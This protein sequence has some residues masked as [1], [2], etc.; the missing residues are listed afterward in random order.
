MTDHAQ[1]IENL[2]KALWALHPQAAFIRVN[3]PVSDPD[4]DC[5]FITANIETA[6]RDGTGGRLVEHVFFINGDSIYSNTGHN[7]ICKAV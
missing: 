2:R 7:F 3:T 1:A 4:Y 5:E 6:R